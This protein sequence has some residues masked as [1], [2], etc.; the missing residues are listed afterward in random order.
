[1]AAPIAINVNDGEVPDSGAAQSRPVRRAHAV[2]G[3]IVPGGTP[4][5]GADFGWASTWGPFRR[6]MKPARSSSVNHA[7]QWNQ[8]SW[9]RQSNAGNLP[10]TGRGLATRQVSATVD[11][12]MQRR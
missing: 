9:S 1:M 11:A 6:L 2:A 4:G 5:A 8:R 3:P 10:R 7:K 12:A